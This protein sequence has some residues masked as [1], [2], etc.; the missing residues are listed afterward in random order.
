MAA[1]RWGKKPRES[2][3][4]RGDRQKSWNS[5]SEQNTNLGFLSHFSWHDLPRLGIDTVSAL[6]SPA[7]SFTANTVRNTQVIDFQL[8]RFGCAPEISFV[9]MWHC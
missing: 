9:C 5:A 6:V 8:L 2:F 1:M 3:L 7:A 4:A